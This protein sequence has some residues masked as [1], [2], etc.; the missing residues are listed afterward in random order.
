[1]YNEELSSAYEIEHSPDATNMMS[2]KLSRHLIPAAKSYENKTIHHGDERYVYEIYG[3]AIM[4][5]LKE[6]K[7][8]LLISKEKITY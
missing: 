8:Q 3:K 1:M 5:L 2:E 6:D 4:N 7:K